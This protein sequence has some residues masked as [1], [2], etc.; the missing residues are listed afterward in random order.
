MF[1]VRPYTISRK[2]PIAH[3]DSCRIRHAKCSLEKPACQSCRKFGF[4]CDWPKSAPAVPSSTSVNRSSCVTRLERTQ[5]TIV[6][7]GQSRLSEG[8]S[9]ATSSTRLLSRSEHLPSPAIQLFAHSIPPSLRSRDA[10]SANSL[11]LS[12]QDRLF[13]DYFPSSAVYCYH[14]NGGS[15]SSFQYICERTA[16]SSSFVMRMILALSASEMHHRGYD[17]GSGAQHS[18]GEDPGLCHYGVAVQE[19]SA[20]LGQSSALESPLSLEIILAAIFLLM[21]YE[22][23][24]PS[25][26]TNVKT[27]LDG[28]WSLLNAHSALMARKIG[29]SRIGSCGSYPNRFPVSCLSSVLLIWIL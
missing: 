9:T 11:I 22:L 15:W 6:P 23:Q 28:L 13:F 19:L 1:D 21:H 25:R 12:R 14:T 29:E 24:F 20:Y 26:Q 18:R 5:R 16:R 4:S 2:R 10:P 8:C 17:L 3:T 7:L 27:H